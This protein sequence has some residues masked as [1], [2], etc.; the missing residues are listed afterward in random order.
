M[1]NFG[2]VLPV[3]VLVCWGVGGSQSLIRDRRWGG[4]SEYAFENLRDVCVGGRV[5]LPM[6]IRQ[7]AQQMTQ[8]GKVCLTLSGSGCVSTHSEAGGGSVL[9]SIPAGFYHN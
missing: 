5:S 7:P 1:T 9:I 4:L 3:R 2:V 6:Q 8:L